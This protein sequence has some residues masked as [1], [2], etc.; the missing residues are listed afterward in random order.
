MDQIFFASRDAEGWM[1]NSGPNFFLDHSGHRAHF[2]FFNLNMLTR[3]ARASS[4]AAG[5]RLYSSKK[6]PGSKTHANLKDAFAGE[7]MVRILSKSS[8]LQC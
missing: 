7:S 6:L 5:R 8:L 2:I 4:R 1:R 3:V